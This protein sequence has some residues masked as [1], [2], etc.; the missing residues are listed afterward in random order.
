MELA[1][2]DGKVTVSGSKT[3]GKKSEEAWLRT[4]GP[5]RKL[6]WVGHSI[7]LGEAKF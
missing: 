2:D 4:K 7:N 3:S 6:R 1:G 5:P